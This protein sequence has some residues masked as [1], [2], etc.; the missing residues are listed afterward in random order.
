[1]WETDTP[2]EKSS[3]LYGKASREVRMKEVVQDEHGALA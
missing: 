3:S 2:E 1:M